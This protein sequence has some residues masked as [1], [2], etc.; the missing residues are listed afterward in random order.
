MDRIAVSWTFTALL[1]ILACAGAQADRYDALLVTDYSGSYKDR[2]TQEYDRVRVLAHQAQLEASMRLGLFQYH[3]GF[4]YPMQIRFDD[5][6]PAGIE[7]ALAY[8]RLGHTDKGFAQ[9]LVINLPVM[10]AAGADFD[11]VFRHEMTHAVM[12]DAVGGEASEKIP[13]WVQEGLAQYVSGE[14]PDRVLQAASQVRPESLGLLLC[15]LNGG[16]QGRCYPQYYLAIQYMADKHSVN[17]VESFVRSLIDGHSM[18][19][20]LQDAVSMP[21]DRFE[22]E[23]RDYSLARYKEYSH[24]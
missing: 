11:Q 18:D 2:F 7:N 6:A 21:F 16:Y 23:V 4:R 24:Y 9:E 22:K 5:G 17:S 1:A 3:D 10:N 20:A 13:H 15:N 14:G 12:N 19:D 8:V